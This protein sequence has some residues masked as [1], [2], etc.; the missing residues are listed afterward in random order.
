MNRFFGKSENIT[1]NRI[2]IEG[3]D[4]K[5]VP[6]NS[7][8]GVLIPTKVRKNDFVYKLIERSQQ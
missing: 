1:E 6:K 8:V 7:N 3:Q 2:M 5:E 4:V